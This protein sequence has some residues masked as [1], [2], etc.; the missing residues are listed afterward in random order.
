VRGPSVSSA[1]RA[2]QPV[3]AALGAAALLAACH[4]SSSSLTPVG[5]TLT[6]V[7]HVTGTPSRTSTARCVF[8][9]RAKVT[10]GGIQTTCL[11]DVDGFP[12]PNA[13]IH[14][15]GEMTFVLPQGTVRT[16]VRVTQR[17]GSDGIH[18]RQQTAGVITSGTGGFASGTGRITGSG[19]VLDR[20]TGIGPVDLT[21]TLMTPEG[22]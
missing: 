5:R 22:G 15:A 19:T 2:V 10:G 17:F 9:L 18:A 20:S 12:G 13:V 8:E 11:R 4:G 6:V 21:Y 1:A 3:I 16:N 7:V 14:S